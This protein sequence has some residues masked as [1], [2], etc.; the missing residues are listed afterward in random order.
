MKLLHKNEHMQY[1]KWWN[2][3]SKEQKQSWNL[4]Q[5]SIQ[6]VNVQN[7]LKLFYPFCVTQVMYILSSACG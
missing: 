1:S 5:L 3:P 7:L 2:K 4:S 6:Q